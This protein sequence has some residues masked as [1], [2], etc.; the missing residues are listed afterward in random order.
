MKKRET[1]SLWELLSEEELARF[2][3]ETREVVRDL[4]GL[5]SDEAAR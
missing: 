3:R 5:Q 4:A 2:S 1:G